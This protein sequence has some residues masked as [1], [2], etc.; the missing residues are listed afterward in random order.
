MDNAA[1]ERVSDRR[2]PP[3]APGLA[4]SEQS[5]H[6]VLPSLDAQQS[7]LPRNSAR[8]VHSGP[9]RR[10]FCDHSAP[11]K[12]EESAYMDS[13]LRALSTPLP[14]VTSFTLSRS[15]LTP[16]L[17]ALLALMPRLHTLSLSQLFEMDSLRFLAP[18][19]DTL[20]SLAL[21]QCRHEELSYEA[22]LEGVC[23]CRIWSSVSRSARA[24][25]RSSTRHSF[26]PLPW[27][28]PCNIGRT[29]SR[30]R[31]ARAHQTD[32]VALGRLGDARR[33]QLGFW[34]VHPSLL[35]ARR[36]TSLSLSLSFPFSAEASYDGG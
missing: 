4:A 28:Q 30:T 5:R 14:L 2:C 24:L 36:H 33:P 9:F 10:A 15:S 12:G 8:A 21:S 3:T 11:T 19:R 23:V 32:S 16:Q 34:D 26:R 35:R 31:I 17:S 25:T 18:L 20:R 27:Y 22:L 13:L 29:G 7:H 6:L 1:D